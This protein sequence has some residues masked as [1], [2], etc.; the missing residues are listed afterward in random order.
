MKVRVGRSGT[1][2]NTLAEPQV[3]P[4]AGVLRNYQVNGTLN[5]Q[6]LPSPFLWASLTFVPSLAHSPA[7]NIPC[8]VPLVIGTLRVEKTAKPSSHPTDILLSR[9][10]GSAVESKANGSQLEQ[11]ISRKVL[12]RPGGPS[13]QKWN[14]PKRSC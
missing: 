11:F 10:I 6:R 3:L 4:V 1:L 14:R 8:G 13:W 9:R 2:L 12:G 7:I 5:G